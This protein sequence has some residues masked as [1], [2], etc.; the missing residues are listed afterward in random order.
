MLWAISPINA[1][2]AMPIIKA[3]IICPLISPCYASRL[4]PCI[5]FKF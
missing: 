2:A 1:P 5:A 3:A 4:Q